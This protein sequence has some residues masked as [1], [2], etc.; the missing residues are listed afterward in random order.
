MAKAVRLDPP[1]FVLSIEGLGGTPPCFDEVRRRWASNFSRRAGSGRTGSQH[2]SG[3]A[4]RPRRLTHGLTDS[5]ASNLHKLAMRDWW[6]VLAAM[7]AGAVSR[8]TD[9]K[10]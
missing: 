3:G 6:K 4:G 10:L 1:L 9:L 5:G 8:A 2:A 7:T